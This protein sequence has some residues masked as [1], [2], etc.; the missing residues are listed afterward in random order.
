MTG[1]ARRLVARVAVAL[2]PMA[3]VMVPMAD[4]AVAAPGVNSA[5]CDPS[6]YTHCVT[7]SPQCDRNWSRNVWTNE[8]KPPPPV[9]D[10]YIPKPAWAPS[11]APAD[12]PPPPPPPPWAQAL[13]L[14][15][16]WDGGSRQWVWIRI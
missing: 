5:Q 10:W 13:Q 1:C 7:S 14:R 6:V 9:P 12:I 2:I 4:V 11:Y 3:A 15:P 8:C 16:I